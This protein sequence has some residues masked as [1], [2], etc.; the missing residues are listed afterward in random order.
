MRELGLDLSSGPV[1]EALVAL[2]AQPRWRRKDVVRVIGLLGLEAM[3]QG[4]P[5]GPSIE[6]CARS[7]LSKVELSHQPT[8]EEVEEAFAAHFAVDPLEPALVSAIGDL[9]RRF[10]LHR[11]PLAPRSKLGGQAALRAVVQGPTSTPL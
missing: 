2:L 3:S 7:L 6:H 5:V 8:S 4:R 11:Q 1:D 9:R 10:R